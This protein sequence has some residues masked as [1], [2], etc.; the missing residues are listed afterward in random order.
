MNLLLFCV[1]VGIAMLAVPVQ[2]GH[3][4]PAV[5][6]RIAQLTLNM[7]DMRCPSQFAKCFGVEKGAL[8][9]MG[10]RGRHL[11]EEIDFESEDEPVEEMTDGTRH[12]LQAPAKMTLRAFRELSR[13]GAIAKAHEYCNGA[14]DDRGPAVF[15]PLHLDIEVDNT[16]LEVAGNP[17]A[18]PEGGAAP[19]A[20][21]Q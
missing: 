9:G 10:G 20:D 6:A 13:A 7:V 17:S 15:F 3:R 14:P 16:P 21:G 19:A 5:A 11:L 12:L 2:G 18:M 4:S 8:L 1:V